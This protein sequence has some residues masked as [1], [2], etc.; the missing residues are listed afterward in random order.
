MAP[1][2]QVVKY[3]TGR[4]VPSLRDLQAAG[5]RTETTIDA[6][7][8]HPA[9]AASLKG[10]Q[11][12]ATLSMA[13]RLVASAKNQVRWLQ[14]ALARSSLREMHGVAAGFDYDNTGTLGPFQFE[15]ALEDMGVDVRK[16]GRSNI[17][18]L[19]SVCDTGALRSGHSR[20]V[21]HICFAK[22]SALN[23][24]VRLHFAVAV[25][26]MTDAALKAA[27]ESNILS[28]CGP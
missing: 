5:S 7:I 15:R 27:M 18:H 17:A 9:V 8:L 2:V 16:L 23:L 24:S 10:A 4:V 13:D 12:D 19:V 28:F 3:L 20:C 11:A 25:C 21:P 26:S 6:S 14:A 22:W 1:C